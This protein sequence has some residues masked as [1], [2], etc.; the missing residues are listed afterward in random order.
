MKQIIIMLFSLMLG[1][2]IFSIVLSDEASL[3]SEAAETMQIQAQEM[4][5]NP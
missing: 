2:H 1:V 4:N 5:M 3:K